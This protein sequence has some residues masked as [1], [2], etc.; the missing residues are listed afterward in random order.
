MPIFLLSKIGILNLQGCT[1]G[2][3]SVNCI[4]SIFLIIMPSTSLMLIYKFF[5]MTLGYLNNESC[6]EVINI[7]IDINTTIN[8]LLK[9]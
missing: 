7:N 4:N 6:L 3:I 5:L 8:R 2:Y 1:R 9:K